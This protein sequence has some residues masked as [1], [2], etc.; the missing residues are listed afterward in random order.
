MMWC[1]N[2]GAV[3]YYVETDQ[4]TGFKTAFCECC[5]SPLELEAWKCE[6]GEWI[7]EEEEACPVCT[8]IV[9]HAVRNIFAELEEVGWSTQGVSDLLDSQIGEYIH[10]LRRTETSK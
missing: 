4:D 1:E 7:S 2:C 8:D 9:R 5:G 3:G 10:D 6:C